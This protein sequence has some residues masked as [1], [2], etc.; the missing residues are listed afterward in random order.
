MYYFFGVGV[1]R[2]SPHLFVRVPFDRRICTVC[3]RLAFDDGRTERDTS[4]E[5]VQDCRAMTGMAVWHH[6]MVIG[7]LMAAVSADAVSM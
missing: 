4:K 6:K 2:I 3:M 7:R 5:D 1:C